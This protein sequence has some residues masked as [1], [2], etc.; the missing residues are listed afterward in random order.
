[1]A[2]V[3]FS[4]RRLAAA[5]VAALA[6]AAAVGGFVAHSSALNRPLRIARGGDLASLDPLLLESTTQFT[7]S[8]VFEGLVRRGRN[9]NLEPALA[10]R[11]TIPD[12]RTWLFELRDGVRFHDGTPVTAAEVK[13]AFD[14]VRDDPEAPGKQLLVNVASIEAVGG[15]SLR[16][17]MNRPEPLLLQHLSLFRIARGR[18]TREVVAQP[19]GTGP[20]RVTRWSRGGKVELQAFEGY[21][22]G[23]PPTRR[24]EIVPMPIEQRLAALSRGE[25]DIA[26]LPP[27]VFEANPHPSVSLIRQVVLSRMYLWMCGMSRR[28]AREPLVDRRVRQ[29]VAMAL[30]RTELSE[31]LLGDRSSAASQLVP[32][33][34]FGFAPAL[35]AART[36]LMGARQL[37]AEAGLPS[38]FE[39]PL[40][41]LAE[42]ALSA[43]TAEAVSRALREIGIKTQLRPVSAEEVLTAFGGRASGFLVSLWTFDDGDAGSFLRDCVRSRDDAAALGLFNPGFSDASMDEAIDS[44]L[45]IIDDRT[46]LERYQA[47]MRRAA[48]EVPVVPL[49]DQVIVVGLVRGLSW[50]PRPDGLILPADISRIAR[51]GAGS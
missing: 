46:R 21:W 5:L 34:I 47:L 29:A 28:A 1:M 17:T 49:F 35:E 38:G 27:E 41:Y 12:D 40:I 24:V 44:A 7:I 20:Y 3:V 8:N 2:S 50:Q 11:W 45:A 4:R 10:V 23:E 15:R 16:F 19:V 18:T 33:T 22:G 14:R 30:D 13:A 26:V 51:P 32:R 6:L 9:L 42:S 43:R 36:N 25:V 39:A 37:L 31:E 48:E